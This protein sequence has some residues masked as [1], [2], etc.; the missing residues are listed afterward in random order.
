[1]CASMNNTVGK[2]K[3]SMFPIVDG[4]LLTVMLRELVDGYQHF[5]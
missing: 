1:M 2:V 3:H 4:G 5:C